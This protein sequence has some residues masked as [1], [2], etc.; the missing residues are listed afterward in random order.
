MQLVFENEC[1][2]LTHIEIYLL[3]NCVSNIQEFKNQI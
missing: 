2:T 1:R 3:N